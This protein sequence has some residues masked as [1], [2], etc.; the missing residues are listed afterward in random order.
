[1]LRE[2]IISR[3]REILYLKK[4]ADLFSGLS[5]HWIFDQLERGS[6]PKEIAMIEHS[7]QLIYYAT[8]WELDLYFI[9]I[10]DMDHKPEDVKKELVKCKKQFLNYFLEMIVEEQLDL[11]MFQIFDSI[12]F[13]IHKNLRPKICLVGYGGVGKTTTA[14]LIKSERIPLEHVPTM[15]VEISTIKIGKLHYSLW[16]FAGQEKFS[17]LW[18]H[19]IKASDAIL[20]I[21]DSTLENVEKSRFFIELAKSEA[22]NA[23]FAVMA[24]KQDL[25][26]AIKPSD[27]ERLLGEKTYEMVATDTLNRDKMLR[28][29]SDVLM[30]DLDTSPLL[31]PLKARDMLM[32]EIQTAI[33]ENNFKEAA[34][35]CEILS[36]VC[37]QIGEYR[38]SMNFA[39][40]AET[41][42][43]YMQSHIV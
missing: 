41:L 16:D 9:F 40:K 43:S 31:K 13:S 35:K 6:N 28:I 3:G 5:H 42:R 12:A 18:N 27:I 14:K 25:P 11:K 1:M 32:D 17:I 8:H 4:F 2:I 36:E 24:N 30:I 37:D 22:P 26:G 19:F 10:L 39:E 33:E 29:I 20:L 21:T 15:N 7:H 38:L 34:I 23:R